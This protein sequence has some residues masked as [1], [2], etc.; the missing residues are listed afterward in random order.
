MGGKIGIICVSL[1]ISLLHLYASLD[2]QA[3]V[4]SALCTGSVDSKW[5]RY[6][7]ETR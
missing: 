7:P 1:P 3:K 2:L 4:M 5:L 6:A